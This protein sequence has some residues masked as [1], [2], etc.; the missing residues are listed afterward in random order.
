M[1]LDKQLEYEL[2]IKKLE[3]MDAD[4]KNYESSKH[5]SI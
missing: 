3:A 2:I 5:L 1:K 4:F